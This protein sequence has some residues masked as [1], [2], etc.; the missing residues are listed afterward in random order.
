MKRLGI[1][2]LYHLDAPL[3]VAH[4]GRPR[5]YVGFCEFGQL[6]KRDKTHHKGERWQ[7]QW[8]GEVKHTGAAAFLAAAVTRGIEFRLVRTWRGTRD[9]ERRLKRQK[10]APLFCPICHP[11]PRRVGF[12]DEIEITAALAAK[13][14]KHA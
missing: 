3:N 10:N 1:I 7:H 13:K 11:Q 9:D 4:R 12:L 8:N 2:Y 14:V 6:P 5:H